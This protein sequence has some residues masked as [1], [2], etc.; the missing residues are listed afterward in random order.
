MYLTAIHL[1][2]LKVTYPDHILAE[3]R[4]AELEAHLLS[5]L[6]TVGIAYLVERWGGDAEG[7]VVEGHQGWDHVV[8]SV[9][10]MFSHSTMKISFRN[11]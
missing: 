10:E 1:C 5:L 2:C 9:E 7:V 11:A 8:R 3:Q 4:T 6:A